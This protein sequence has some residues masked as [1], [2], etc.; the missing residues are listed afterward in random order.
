MGRYGQ[1]SARRVDLIGDY[2]GK[3]LFLLEGDSLLLHC[4]GDAKLDFDSKAIRPSCLL[5]SYL[6]GLTVCLLQLDCNFCMRSISLNGFSKVLFKDIVISIL[7]SSRPTEHYVF[8][9]GSLVARDRDILWPER[10]FND[11]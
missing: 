9:G 4:F 7:S 10:L 11:I 8:H 1:Q 5:C 2:A 3:E 6:L